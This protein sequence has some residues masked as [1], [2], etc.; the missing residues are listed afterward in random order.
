MIL[1][2]VLPLPAMVAALLMP[3]AAVAD[4]SAPGS[5]NNSGLWVRPADVL[6]SRLNRWRSAS[7]QP[8]FDPR[9]HQV[10]SCQAAKCGAD[11]VRVI[12]QVT[13][14]K[15]RPEFCPAQH[16]ERA[17]PQQCLVPLIHG[18]LV[19][20][21]QRVRLPLCAPAAVALLNKAPKVVGGQARVRPREINN[22]LGV[23]TPR[24]E[25]GIDRMMDDA[26]RPYDPGDLRECTI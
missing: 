24:P 12:R 6:R 13:L 8:D 9:A 4:A 10:A 5:Q 22:G 23:A 18:E 19:Q 11:H 20:G 3:T 7:P 16:L 26:A 17:V 2:R 25:K 1:Q 21:T 15:W 14:T